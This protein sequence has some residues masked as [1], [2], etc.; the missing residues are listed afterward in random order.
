MLSIGDLF[1]LG[2]F[3]TGFTCTFFRG[4]N[5]LF[6]ILRCFSI[7]FSPCFILLLH[8]FL[9][10]S[11]YFIEHVLTHVKLLRELEP[12]V[13]FHVAQSVHVENDSVEMQDEVAYLHH[14]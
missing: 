1:F 12:V 4:I 7:C 10:P 11:N 13:D 14:S 8:S 3:M 2:I 6:C 5:F 9:V